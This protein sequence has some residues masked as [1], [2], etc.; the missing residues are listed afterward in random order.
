[1]RT[2]NHTR[3]RLQNAFTMLELVFVIIVLGILTALALPRLDRDFKQGAMDKVLAAIRYTQHMALTD[4]RHAFDNALWQRSFWQIS[5]R[6]CANNTGM[7]YMIGSDK[8][9]NGAIGRDEA[10]MDTISKKPMF[11]LTANECANGGDG[12]VS[13]DIFLTTK[14]NITGIAG[15][16]GCA[17]AQYIGFDH[18]GRPHVNFL[19]SNS[20]NYSSYMRQTCTFTFTMADGDSFQ[21]QIQP[22]SGYAN[23]VSVVAGDGLDEL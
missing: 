18:L 3:L 22:E 17:G 5:F 7:F 19:G 8:N 16:G 4:F 20:P 15:A 14:W 11:W 10:A 2:S 13:E 9:Y 21:I 1:M 6:S 23:I 12:T